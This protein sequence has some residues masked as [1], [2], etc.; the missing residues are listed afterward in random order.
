M[1]EENVNN[2]VI[3]K[4]PK[5]KILIGIIILLVASNALA[6]YL[7]Q[8]KIKSVDS[9]N[10]PQIVT[11][12]STLQTPVIED[13]IIRESGHYFIEAR[14]LEVGNYTRFYVN[15]VLKGGPGPGHSREYASHD[16]GIPEP[17]I[18]KIY[19]ISEDPE[20][21]EKS[22]KSNI[23]TINLPFE[24]EKEVSEEGQEDLEKEQE[25]DSNVPDELITVDWNEWTQ[26]VDF[27][28]LFP[29]GLV[30]NN[31]DKRESDFGT[32]FDFFIENHHIYKVGKVA[33]G[34]YGGSELFVVLAPC[35]GMC[36][37][38]L[39]RIIKTED[40]LIYI[41]K[42]SQGWLK[43]YDDIL[44]I[45]HGIVISNMGTPDSI[46][47]PDS[48]SRLIKA[49]KEKYR[50]IDREVGIK[51]EL[52]EY[53]SNKA[54]YKN[55]DNCFVIRANDGSVQEYYLEIDFITEGA[56]KVEHTG[57]IPYLVDFAFL[58]GRK[59]SEEYVFKVA[60]GGCG[61]ENCYA[62]ADR[63]INSNDQL[64]IIGTL[65]SG[66]SVYI[67]KDINTKSHPNSQ[68]S[69]LEYMYEQYYPGYDNDKKEMKEKISFEEFL[70]DYPLIFV[71]DSF[72]DYIELGNAKYLSAVEC[73]KPVIYLYPEE[74]M[75]VSVQV[76]PR[77]GFLITEPA[78]NN[79][80][81]VKANPSGELYNYSDKEEYPY[82]FWEGFGINYQRPERGFVVAKEDVE[83]FLVEKLSYL[84]LVKHEYDEFIE[85]WL[86]KMQE[87]D[88][89]FITFIPQSEFDL[90]APLAVEPKPDTVIRVFMDYEGLDNYVEVPEQRLEKGVRKGFTVIE[91]GGA[92][93]K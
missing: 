27:N 82:L 83:K 72:G 10:N 79:G 2:E 17:G 55:S 35:D 21:G 33:S 18:Y 6:F 56:E 3:N 65:N 66:G 71:K 84:G 93:H 19:A 87:Q 61:N 75:D 42:Q 67:L 36:F 85:F 48:N 49:D 81:L 20:T 4:S 8:K 5:S 50:M 57:Q 40:K 34:D 7:Y 58:D 37:G 69:I 74:E 47:I 25:I 14:N 32:N 73:G 39:F 60:A 45:D 44:T 53:S 52:F 91:W 13:V 29:R 9:E 26:K 89:Y 46:L 41:N 64:E 68:K 24:E 43:V 78:Y 70:A 31:F 22:P 30:K 54:V 86:P 77:G 1:E 88:Y 90:L 11:T 51:K 12:P 59:N 16:I 92:L 63:Y 76:A 80:W 15:D 23:I 28:S 38:N 62:Y